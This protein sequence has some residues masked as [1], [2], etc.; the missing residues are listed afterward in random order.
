MREEGNKRKYEYDIV[1][2]GQLVLDIVFT[3]EAGVG[4]I[5]RVMLRG[6]QLRLG[7]NVQWSDET[8]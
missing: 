3:Q 2:Q 5:V 8:Y 4:Y 7:R 1:V 6:H